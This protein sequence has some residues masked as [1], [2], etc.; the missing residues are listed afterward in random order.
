MMLAAFLVALPFQPA[1]KGTRLSPWA[2]VLN[3]I[4][5]SQLQNCC[6][7]GLS[8]PEHDVNDELTQLTQE[9][10]A[11]PF[12]GWTEAVGVQEGVGGL[13]VSAKAKAGHLPGLQFAVGASQ[14][15]LGEAVSGLCV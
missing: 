4:V 9:E 11:V 12:P 10:N 1:W 2:D 7:D 3:R 6:R 8:T 14:G 15:F 5:C 13:L